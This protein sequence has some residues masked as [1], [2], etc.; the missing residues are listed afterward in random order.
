MA[1]APLG[2]R[3]PP[4]RPTDGGIP[5]NPLSLVVLLGS[6]GDAWI[7]ALVAIRG[8]RRWLQATFAACTLAFLINGAAFVGTTEGLWSQTPEDVLLG[9]LLLSHALTAILVLGLIHGEALPRKRAAAFLLLVPVPVLTF[10][11]PSQGW[12]AATAF[13]ETVLGGFLVLCFGIALAEAIYARS[14]S[15]MFAPHAFWIAVGIVALIV[16]GPVYTYELLIL[17]LAPLAGANVAVPVGLACFARVALQ[18]R[19]FPVRPKVARGRTTAGTVRSADAILFDEARPKYALRVAHE[20]AQANRPTLIVKR[21]PPPIT[22]SGASFAAIEGGRHAAERTLTTA[23]DFLATA[24]G[25]LVVLEDLADLSALSG[26]RP[27]RE[28][29]VRLRHVARGTASTAIVCPSRLTES[30]RKSLADLALATWTLPDPAT[31]IVAILGQSFGSGAGRLVDSFCRGHGLRRDDLTTDHVPALLAFLSRVLDDLTGVV[32]DAAAHGLRVQFEAAGSVLRSFALQRAE[33]V[34]RGKWPSRRAIEEETDLVVTAKDYWK[35]REMEELFA[36]ADA[37][38]EREPLYERARVV[39]VEQLGDSGEGVL[40][41][42]LARLGKRPEDL[43][44]RDLARIADRTSMDL[45]S[46]AE[47]V[48]VPVEKD[49]IQ[50]QIE[51]IRQRLESI[52]EDPE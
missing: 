12:T 9:I 5:L 27:V 2:R 38:L 15:P 39:F 20:E 34:A 41:T 46:V 17:G 48:D 29:L 36:A 52:A 8:R 19:P 16:G 7:L 13:D 40:Q 6:A 23:S 11:A 18:T 47:V 37:V 49:R 26:W 21:R 3:H 28:A 1:V 25:G 50:R 42:Q 10:L 4:P 24:P 51:S 45:K 14:A 43:E 30:E 33:E 22:M 31:E 35:G 44:K 32:S